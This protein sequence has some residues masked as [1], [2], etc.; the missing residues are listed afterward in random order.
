MHRGKLI[1]RGAPSA[2]VSNHGASTAVVLV[3]AGAAGLAEVKAEGFDG[4]LEGSDVVVPVHG[5]GGAKEA[6]RRLSSL[7]TPFDE[8]YTRRQTLED[9]F[10][11]LVGARMEEG[12]LHE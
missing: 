8:L 5:N 6:L 1:E 10:L 9:I 12:V 3:G 11:K 2:L 7:S 4:L